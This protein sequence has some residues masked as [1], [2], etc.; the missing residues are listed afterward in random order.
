MTGYI[1][2]FPP[3]RRLFRVGYPVLHAVCGPTR[4]HTAT[5]SLPRCMEHTR[6]QSSL[7]S[8]RGGKKAQKGSGGQHSGK[9]RGSQ[10]DSPEVRLS[11]TVSW[12]L[13]HGAVQEGLQLRPDGYARVQDL[14]SI[15]TLRSSQTQLIPT[16][17][18]SATETQR[19]DV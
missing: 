19:S 16:K 3:P 5:P 7:N 2:R 14:V 13:R 12:I 6:H 18:A 9:L 17:V 15:A 10:H 11:K 1:E 4:V 8:Q